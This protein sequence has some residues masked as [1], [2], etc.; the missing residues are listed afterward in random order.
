MGDKYILV[1]ENI[2]GSLAYAVRVHEMTHVLQW[3]HKKWDFTK[4]GS[5]KNEREAFEVSNVV[6]RR[7]GNYR[8]LVDWDKMRVVY[9][10]PL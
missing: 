6:L 3:K 7:L 9:G 1:N 8:D 4:A 2:S 5:C 10:C